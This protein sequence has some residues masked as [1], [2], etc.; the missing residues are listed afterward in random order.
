M[1][2]KIVLNIV[3]MTALISCSKNEDKNKKVNEKNKVSSNKI[4]KNAITYSKPHIESCCW[5]DDYSLKCENLHSMDAIYLRVSQA[6]NILNN[7]EQQDENKKLMKDEDDLKV[8]HISF[9]Q[10]QSIK[11]ILSLEYFK[12]KQVLLNEKNKEIFDLNYAALAYYA[13]LVDLCFASNIILDQKNNIW[14]IPKNF[15]SEEREHILIRLFNFEMQY[16]IRLSE[17]SVLES[18]VHADSEALKKLEKFMDNLN[19]LR[20][21]INEEN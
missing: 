16:N 6:K 13:L 17:K 19:L 5:K 14:Q 12:L 3:L 4:E 11:T 2:T 15:S 8:L 1:R 21:T 20:E 9:E 18:K 10:K 7:I